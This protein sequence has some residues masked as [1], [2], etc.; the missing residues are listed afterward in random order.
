MWQTPF[1]GQIRRGLRNTLPSDPDG[2]R[3]LLLP[4]IMSKPN[5]L[6]VVSDE[7]RLLRFATI[8]GFIGML[9]PHSLK[10]LDQGSFIVVT[11]IGNEMTMPSQ[12]QQFQE[13]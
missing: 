5:F 3:P 7:Q 9:R 13:A 8:L 4:L 10:E 6:L 12:P 2:R 11:E 1:L